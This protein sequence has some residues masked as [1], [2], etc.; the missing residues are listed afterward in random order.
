MVAD[1]AQSAVKVLALPALDA[2]L[3][4]AQDLAAETEAHEEFVGCA[5]SDLIEGP[6]GAWYWD[7]DL[8]AHNTEA[9]IS[10]L[11]PAIQ[12]QFA[13]LQI[14]HRG[15]WAWVPV[16]DR[17]LALVEETTAMRADEGHR[18]PAPC[19]ESLYY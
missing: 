10:D 6:G 13:G 7:D 16:T 12:E 18:P 5:V 4:R 14:D 3:L 1:D 9:L 11:Q 15:M 17:W 8:D 19:E 2:G